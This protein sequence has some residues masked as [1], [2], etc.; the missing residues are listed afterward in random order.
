MVPVRAEHRDR[1]VSYARVV[2]LASS[3]AA[4]R[5]RGTK[6]PNAS[7]DED[8]KR[9]AGPSKHGE[10]LEVAKVERHS[11]VH[12]VPP[13]K[14]TRFRLASP[15]E[16][17]SLQSVFYME[18]EGGLYWA[19]PKSLPSVYLADQEKGDDDED[20]DDEDEED[21]DEE[22]EE[23]E[24]EDED[25]D[26]DDDDDEEGPDDSGD[27]DVEEEEAAPPPKASKKGKKGATPSKPRA[28]AP[29]AKL[30][31]KGK[32]PSRRAA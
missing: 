31:A 27:E 16:L 14:V 21:D 29:P 15:A 17:W 26:D 2:P 11:T 1:V 7:D 3:V 10:V 12:P 8:G 4:D 18:E 32:K 13:G 24:D 25:E 23:E 9:A 20:D 6:R 30:P 5:R 19:A 28:K 22:E